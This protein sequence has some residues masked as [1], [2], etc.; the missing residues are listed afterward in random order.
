MSKSGTAAPTPT[1][2]YRGDAVPMRAIRKFAR[3]VAERFDVEKIILFGSYAYGT[4]HEGSDVDIL[5][6]MET[7]KGLD[8]AGHI[9]LAVPRRFPMDLL[10]WRPDELRRGLE[11]GNWF[12]REIASKGKVL[13]ERP[14][15]AVGGKSRG[16]L[17]RGSPRGRAK[18]TG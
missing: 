12:L 17:A 15:Q 16:R 8:Q 3:Q 18:T 11:Q 5:V 13:Y 7:N 1:R 10:V 6:V 4:P 9:R 14:D 2:W